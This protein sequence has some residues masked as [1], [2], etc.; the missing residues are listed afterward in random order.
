MK[1]QIW[2]NDAWG[3]LGWGCTHDI[4]PETDLHCGPG[5]VSVR[6]EQPLFLFER[7]LGSSFTL[8]WDDVEFVCVLW[9]VI[10]DLRWR[11][12]AS[13]KIPYSVRL[14][15]AQVTGHMHNRYRRGFDEDPNLTVMLKSLTS[16][17]IASDENEPVCRWEYLG[18]S[19]RRLWAGEQTRMGVRHVVSG[20]RGSL[21]LYQLDAEY[22]YP[23]PFYK[24][25]RTHNGRRHGVA[26]VCI[27]CTNLVERGDLDSPFCQPCVQFLG[28]NVC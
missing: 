19:Q 11:N 6:L 10:E 18:L 2:D 21:P 25:Y 7:R 15:F 23:D 22:D 5:Y 1:L 20:M 17:K 13:T 26:S 3:G 27:R 12:R 24:V 4:N 8:T 16:Y 14:V 28:F 9:N